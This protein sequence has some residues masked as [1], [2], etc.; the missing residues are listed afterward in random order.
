MTSWKNVIDKNKKQRNESL[1]KRIDEM[2]N[3]EK[4]K[5]EENEKLILK[6]K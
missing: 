3:Y 2:K 1:K 5:Q 4:Q 6:K